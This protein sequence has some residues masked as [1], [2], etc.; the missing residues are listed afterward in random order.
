MF[1]VLAVIEVKDAENDF[2]ARVAMG[3]L[4]E[5]IQA[6]LRAHSIT[7]TRATADD[8]AEMQSGGEE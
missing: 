2:D 3:K 4:R 5:D 1:R 7:I 6:S 8:V